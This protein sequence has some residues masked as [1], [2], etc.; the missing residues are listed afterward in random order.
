[1][2][3]NQNFEAEH[4]SR[5]MNFNS[6]MICKLSTLN[7]WVHRDKTLISPMNIPREKN[8]VFVLKS[9]FENENSAEK[10]C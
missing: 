2:V 6:Y 4:S 3:L 8:H 5:F 9:H 1:M 10:R 7:A